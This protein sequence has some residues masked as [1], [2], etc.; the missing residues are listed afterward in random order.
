MP[1][2]NGIS[3]F[4]ASIVVGG[5]ISYIKTR[6]WLNNI[7]LSDDLIY[8]FYYEL[9]KWFERH[10]I[11]DI[12]D[13]DQFLD[14]MVEVLKIVEGEFDEKLLDDPE[15]VKKTLKKH[16]W[17]WNIYS[18]FR[19]YV[20]SENVKT[21][22]DSP[23]TKA[24]DRHLNKSMISIPKLL[25]YKVRRDVDFAL[26]DLEYEGMTTVDNPVFEETMEG[27]TSLGGEMRLTAPWNTN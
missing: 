23:L 6:L 9:K 13:K 15:Y 21:V 22:A 25:D 10:N 17:L 8:K 1:I 2:T 26:E 18:L 3:D 12:I 24:I 14:I 19:D 20:T 4:L 27:E 11:D 5:A 16:A 7:H